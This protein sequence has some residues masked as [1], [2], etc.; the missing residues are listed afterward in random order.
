MNSEFDNHQDKKQIS[1]LSFVLQFLQFKKRSALDHLSYKFLI[2]SLGLSGSVLITKIALS[3]KIRRMLKNL[4]L[5]LGF[6]IT[7]MVVT[8]S[9][10]AIIMKKNQ[11]SIAPR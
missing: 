11:K 6:S 9:T 8:G 1:Y 7:V 10:V 5:K 3:T 2:L 4:L